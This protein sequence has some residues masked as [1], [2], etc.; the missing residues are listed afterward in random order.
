MSV[1]IILIIDYCYLIVYNK[2]WLLFLVIWLVCGFLVGVILSGLA[3]Y[4]TWNQGDDITLSDMGFAVLGLLFV[5]TGGLISVGYFLVE[6][7]R[8]Q[9]SITGNT[10]IIPGSRSAKTI[11]A[12]SAKD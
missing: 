6:V 12:L 10:I 9:F 1:F 11:K 8:S 4:M 2:V 3:L 5:T 7:L